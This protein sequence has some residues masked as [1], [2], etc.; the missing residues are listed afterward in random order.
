MSKIEEFERHE[1][2]VL[3]FPWVSGSN[4]LRSLVKQDGEYLK[5][6]HALQSVPLLFIDDLFKG[7]KHPTEFQMEF[8][9]DVI[10]ERYMNHLPVMLSSEKTPDEI[11]DMRD[12]K[13][14]RI[15]E[16]VGSR[17]YEMTKNYL[18]I[19]ELLPGEE[20]LSLNYRL[21]TP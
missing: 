3:Y 12:D 6:L 9:F 19:M 4:E 11:M 21:M 17:L 7:R 2:G 16:G 5:K 13:G 14:E 10:N 15:G 18:S 8:L 1:L 20:S